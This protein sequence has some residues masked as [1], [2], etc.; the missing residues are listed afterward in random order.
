MRPR[1]ALVTGASRGIGRAIA[2]SLAQ[3]GTFV[4]FTYA[5]NEAAA[6]ETTNAIEKAGGKALSLKADIGSMTGIQRLFS[7]LEPE[8]KK[9]CGTTEIDVLVNNAGIGAWGSITEVTE[10]DFDAAFRVNVKGTFFVTRLAIPRLM[11]GGRIITISSGS[12]RRPS[13]LFPA[14]SMT[15]AALDAFTISLAA[16][17]GSRRITANT[18]APGWTA[19]D[20]NE[21][22]RAN[23]E[24]VQLVTAKT[25][26]GRLGNPGDIAAV[27]RFLASDDSAWVTGQYIEVSGGYGLLM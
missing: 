22:A 11:D 17:L 16:D 27:V 6:N 14:Y 13:V 26:L 12:S 8:L 5:G 20:I 18:V 23:P 2:E 19:T 9:H 10:Q 1:I 4:A 3:D 21:K 24:V 15:K 25:A 7:N